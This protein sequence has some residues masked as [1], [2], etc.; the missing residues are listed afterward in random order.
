MTRRPG[1]RDSTRC[2]AGGSPRCGG[3]SGLRLPAFATARTRLESKW[4]RSLRCWPGC[5][6]G[7]V[8][9]F[10]A[11][12]SQVRLPAKTLR[13]KR[14]RWSCWE[15]AMPS[16]TRFRSR[17]KREFRSLRWVGSLSSSWVTPFLLALLRRTHRLSPARRRAP[18]CTRLHCSRTRAT[19][20]NTS[21]RCRIFGL[22]LRPEVPSCAFE[23]PSRSQLTG[24]SRCGSP[25]STSDWPMT[26]W[27][28]C[29]S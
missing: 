7:R 9:P 22:G 10:G 13:C 14:S 6:R 29:P 18:S 11:H 16:S 25:P 20:L 5:R 2:C 19:V 26:V 12:L 8:S 4:W 23:T 21:A 24:F 28:C 3:R 27:L 1:L 17:T 15:A